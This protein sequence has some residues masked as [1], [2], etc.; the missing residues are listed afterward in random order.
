M[1]ISTRPLVHPSRIFSIAFSIASVHLPTIGANRAQS[2]AISSRDNKTLRK[3]KI[4]FFRAIYFEFSDGPQLPKHNTLFFLPPLQ[5]PVATLTS[6]D[7]EK[8][9]AENFFS[10]SEK[11]FSV[12][13]L[14][15]FFHQKIVENSKDKKVTNDFG[16][17]FDV[18]VPI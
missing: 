7:K 10:V 15:S 12:F 2:S 14:F 11:L 16:T 17:S 13:R 8:K 1:Q 5:T 18:K 9:T 6:V 3:F 4:D